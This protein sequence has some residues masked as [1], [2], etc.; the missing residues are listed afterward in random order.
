MFEKQLQWT[1]R[2]PQFFKKHCANCCDLRDKKW[3]THLNSKVINGIPYDFF[4]CNYPNHIMERLIVVNTNKDT[5]AWIKK[6]MA[7]P[8]GL[9][10]PELLQE[11]IRL[12]DEL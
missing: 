3:G 6:H 5:V 1:C 12:R 11:M 2:Q 7:T 4:L 8:I 9:D 10:N